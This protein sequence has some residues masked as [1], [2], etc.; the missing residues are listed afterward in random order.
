MIAPSRM[1]A[2][3]ILLTAT[4]ITSTFFFAV[5]PAP[6]IVGVLV[7]VI[8]LA[9]GRRDKRARRRFAIPAA[10][11]VITTVIATMASVTLVPADAA[12]RPTDSVR[13]SYQ[14]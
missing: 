1:Y 7:L 3:P 6:L 10:T 8:S 12:Q 4:A 11:A 9:L 5:F 14:N 13:V 2:V